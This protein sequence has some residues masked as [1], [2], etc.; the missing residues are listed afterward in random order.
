[1]FYRLFEAVSKD[2]E[3]TAHGREGYYFANEGDF[4]MYDYTAAIGEVLKEL[5]NITDATPKPFTEAESDEYFTVS[6]STAPLITSSLY[7]RLK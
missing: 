7:S 5:G 1:M 3:G 2:A 6:H 4:T